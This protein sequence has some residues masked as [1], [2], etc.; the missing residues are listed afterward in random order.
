MVSGV[1]EGAGGPLPLPK[2]V[3]PEPVTWSFIP[4]PPSLRAGASPRGFLSFAT[5]GPRD[6]PALYSWGQALAWSCC[7]FFVLFLSH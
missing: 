5:W 7:L 3:T 1:G 6:L 2:R 4:V